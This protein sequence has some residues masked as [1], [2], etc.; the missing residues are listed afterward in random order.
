M[1]E[2]EGGGSDHLES[3]RG[4]L[5]RGTCTQPLFHFDKLHFE[6]GSLENEGKEEKLQEADEQEI[7]ALRNNR[8]CGRI[9]GIPMELNVG[10]TP[11]QI[12]RF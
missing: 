5:I 12:A 7:Q 10:H 8:A 2:G 6:F 11:K 3:L 1:G 9:V 4:G